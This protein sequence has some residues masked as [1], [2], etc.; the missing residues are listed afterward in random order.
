MSVVTTE[1]T[2]Y[3]GDTW[4]IAIPGMDSLAARTKLWFTVKRSKSDY[5]SAALVMIEETAGLLYIAGKAAATAANG[6]ITVT[7]AAAG[8]ITVTVKGTETF[9]L[10]VVD[11][12][13]YDV[14][15]LTA[16]GPKT[17]AIGVFN[18]RAD[19]TRVTA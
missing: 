3:R 19:V 17:M 18:I 14:Q 8:N 2:E 15:M 6:S 11:D 12:I 13:F 10:P 9:K 7:N 16:S 5:D 1:Q 4:T